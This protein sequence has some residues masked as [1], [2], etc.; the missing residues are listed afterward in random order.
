MK[1]FF[2][3][4]WETDYKKKVP[5]IVSPEFFFPTS[6]S[7]LPYRLLNDT[8][9]QQFV[10]KKNVI[11]IGG[12]NLLKLVSVTCLFLYYSILYLNSCDKSLKALHDSSCLDL[13]F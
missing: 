4:F 13:V 1:T 2:F 6:L 8:V 5:K 10:R 3:S 11:T 9:C 7:G 12:V